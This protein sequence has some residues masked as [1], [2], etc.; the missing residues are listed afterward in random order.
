MKTRTSELTKAVIFEFI[1]AAIIAAPLF[2]LV[3]V[4][5]GILKAII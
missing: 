5:M 4:V 1:T 2:V 3:N